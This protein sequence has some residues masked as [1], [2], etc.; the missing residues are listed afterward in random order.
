ME[1]SQKKAIFVLT[2]SPLSS[3]E[4]KIFKA[5][6]IAKLSCSKI[7]HTSLCMYEI[8]SPVHADTF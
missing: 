3:A 5:L 6:K 8:C 7:V 2:P 4:Q 1:K